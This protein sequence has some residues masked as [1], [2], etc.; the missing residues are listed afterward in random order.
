[1]RNLIVAGLLASAVGLLAQPSG[2]QT[3]SQQA[4]RPQAAQDQKTPG[5]QVQVPKP[6]GPRTPAATKPVAPQAS[7]VWK[8]RG[9]MVVNGGAL[10]AAPSYTST[11][12]Y[13][14]YAENATLDAHSTIGIGPAFG[15]RGGMRVWRNLAVG[16][17][18]SVA[19]ASQSA[20]VTG[21][22]PHPFMFNQFRDVKGTASGLGRLETMAAFEAS[23]LVA[24]S[25]RFDMF[26]FGGP[27]Y[28]NIQQDM[29][30]AIRFTE[31][32]P[33]DTATFTGVDS[34]KVSGSAVGVT[35]G[36][37]IAY[38]LTKSLGLGGQ[39]RYSYA[40]A[41]MKPGGQPASVGL[42][43]LHLS[44]GARVLF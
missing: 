28:F 22:L 15:A 24:L 36:A 13:T 44:V 34:A 23:W 16:G 1:M 12:N 6:A 40:S 25:R 42:G 31:S 27:G 18:F 38:L 37:D 2:A 32:Y 29:A 20:E 5:A 17:A 19:S 21:R 33:F 4:A 35:A 10:M 7:R 8:G 14:L 39:V 11:V 30:T 26:V 41:T 9:F 3:S 43:G